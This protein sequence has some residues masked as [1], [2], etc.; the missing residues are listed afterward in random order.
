MHQKRIEGRIANE[1]LMMLRSRKKN[2]REV[3]L[4][5]PIGTD[6]E[7]N[8]IQIYD[9]CTDHEDILSALERR[10]SIEALWKAM[11]EVLDAREKDVVMRRYGLNGYQEETQQQVGQHYHISRSYVSRLEKRALGKLRTALEKAR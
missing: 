10:E 9:L 4:Y 5:E 6:K 8:E 1:L 3:S 7:G 11:D 2:A